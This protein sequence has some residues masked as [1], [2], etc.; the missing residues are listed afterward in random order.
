M[1][2]FLVSGISGQHQLVKDKQK[3]ALI[4]KLKTLQHQVSGTVWALDEDTLYLENFHYDGKG[5]GKH[6]IFNL[7]N[8]L[9]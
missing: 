4:G 5:P 8:K 1:N 2:L 3:G 9:K 6:S 7:K